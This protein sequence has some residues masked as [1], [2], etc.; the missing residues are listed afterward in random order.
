VVVGLAFLARNDGVLLG[1]PFALAFLLD[2]V[3]QPRL[4]RIGWLP[5]LVCVGG[6]LLVVVPWLLRQLDVFGSISPSSASG[7]ILFISEYRELYSVTSEA[8]L[9]SFLGQGLATVIE[10]RL[11]GLR[12]ALLI[13]VAMPLL[14]L[15]LP[16]LLIGA[17]VKRRSRDFSPWL[18]YVAVLFAF[19][20]IVSAVHVRYGTFIHSAVALLPHAYLL[21]MVAVA[22]VVSW[23]AARRPS[24]H[25]E[26]AARNLSLMLAGVIIVVAVPATLS[27]VDAWRDERD[28]RVE[29][30]AALAETADPAD[31]VMSPDAGAY[32]YH[33]GWRGIVTPD[34]P[35]ETVAQAMRLYDVRWLALEG[36][37]VTGA[38]RPVLLGETRPDWLSAPLVL[39]PPLDI[40]ESSGDGGSDGHSDAPVPRAAL[41]AVCF[42][43]EDDRC[44]P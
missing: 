14:G 15:L 13:F 4:S 33:G 7:R 34:D 22:A 16:F 18:V 28:D 21:V 12:D 9:E 11:A 37:H 35:L 1:V 43:P 42:E 20:A 19:T 5:A 10:S 27:T 39:G 23:I 40:D 24:W 38:L 36:A 17:W 44:A 2:L 31:I 25:A 26:R 6:F 41:Y 32:R 3:R 29:V 8:T 30:L